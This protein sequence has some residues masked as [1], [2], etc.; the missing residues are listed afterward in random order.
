MSSD[1]FQIPEPATIGRL[2]AVLPRARLPGLFVTGTDTGVGKTAVSCAVIAALR[3]EGVRR[4][5]VFKPFVTG[6]RREREGLV[7]EDSEALAYFA[8]SRHPLTTISPIRFV[9]PLAPGAAAEETDTPI[10]WSAVAAALERLL[11]G[12]DALVVEGVGGLLVPLEPGRPVP[13]VLELAAALGFPALVVTR[14]GLGTL[15]HTAL[16]TAALRAAG[17]RLAGLVANGHPPDDPNAD[18][19]VPSNR[20]WLERM[21]GTPLLTAV[22]AC[23]SDRVDPAGGRLPRAFLDAIA[24]VRWRERLAPPDRLSFA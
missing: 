4:V 11:A 16:T 19:S 1:G 2:R 22:P 24:A 18:P 9:A 13:T 3:L 8:D 14:A 21:T 17:C 5:G 7:G 20:I 23:A 15:N 6:C 10:D 12:S